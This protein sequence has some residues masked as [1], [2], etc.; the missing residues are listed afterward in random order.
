MRSRNGS[1]LAQRIALSLRCLGGSSERGSS[2]D[3]GD[4]VSPGIGSFNL[5]LVS[6][7]MSSYGF[8]SSFI[9]LISGEIRLYISI[10]DIEVKG[11]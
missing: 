7:K 6:L 10:N 4:K 1:L 2:I 3:G 11:V 5:V 8:S 9:W